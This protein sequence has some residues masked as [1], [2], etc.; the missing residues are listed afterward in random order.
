MTKNKKGAIMRDG[1]GWEN[2]LIKPA[3]GELR[4]GNYYC[5]EINKLCGYE[6]LCLCT[7]INRGRG[8]SGDVH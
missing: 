7:K 1:T 5:N 6:I 2:H 8:T 4:A 3:L